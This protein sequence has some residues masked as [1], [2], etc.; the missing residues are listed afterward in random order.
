M[1]FITIAGNIGKAP[2][3]RQ[4]QSGDSVLSFSVADSWQEKGERK[5]QWYECSIFGT[6]AVKLQPFIRQGG[7][8]TV[9]GQLRPRQ[10][11][12]KDGQARVSFD[13]RVHDIAMQDEKLR[14]KTAEKGWVPG[15]AFKAAVGAAPA[16][17]S[18]EDIPF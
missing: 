1:N 15:E 16:D 17:F 5:T 7:K 10:Y 13:V 8:V 9:C 2:E 14:D 11:Q 12:G 4:L 6:R 18:D 3:M